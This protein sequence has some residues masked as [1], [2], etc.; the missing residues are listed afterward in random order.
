MEKIFTFSEKYDI[1]MC[2]GYGHSL[3]KYIELI[4]KLKNIKYVILESHTGKLND[5]KKYNNI[6]ISI[7]NVIYDKVLKCG[8]NWA[9]KK[10]RL[11]IYQLR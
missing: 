8:D 1:I 4:I 11:V 2:M 10:R 7:Y 6:L 9:L 5:F 3:T